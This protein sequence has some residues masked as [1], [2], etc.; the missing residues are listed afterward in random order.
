M[1]LGVGDGD[2]YLF[3][4]GNYESIKVC[5]EKLIELENLRVENEQLKQQIVV[6]ELAKAIQED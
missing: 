3:V 2:G 5:Q 6:L 1:K 4:E